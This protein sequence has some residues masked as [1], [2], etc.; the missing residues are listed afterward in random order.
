MNRPESVPYSPA[1]FGST[2]STVIGVFSFHQNSFIEINLLIRPIM[3]TYRLRCRKGGAGVLLTIL[4][5][6]LQEVLQVR[7]RL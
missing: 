5:M 1:E 2:I 7:I 6:S 3:R 4:P